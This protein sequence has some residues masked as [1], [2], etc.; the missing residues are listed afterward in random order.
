MKVFVVDYRFLCLLLLHAEPEFTAF[1]ELGSRTNRE[2]IF[3][4]ET[5]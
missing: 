3:L 5:L 4:A 1:L 2:L